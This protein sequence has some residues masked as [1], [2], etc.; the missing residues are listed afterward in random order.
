M[1]R[2]WWEETPYALYA[3]ISVSVLLCLK[4][5]LFDDCFGF[6]TNDDVNHTFVGLHVAKQALSAGELPRIHSR[7][8]CVNLGIPRRGEG[9]VWV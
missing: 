4:F 5:I 9:A 8:S 1:R 3:A 7:V 2:F 6:D